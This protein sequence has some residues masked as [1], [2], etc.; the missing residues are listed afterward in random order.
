M[1][2]KRLQPPRDEAQCSASF[3]SPY[4]YDVRVALFLDPRLVTSS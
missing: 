3:F 1:A 2:S 4:T